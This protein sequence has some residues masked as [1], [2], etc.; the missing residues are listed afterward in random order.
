MIFGRI[1]RAV[2]YH[3]RRMARDHYDV[4]GVP[5]SSSPEEI[6]AA[7][8]KLAALHHPDRNPNDPS[9]T[10]RFKEVTAAYQVL[11]DTGRRNMYDR[12]GHQAEASGSPFG[13]GGPF[14]GG[15]VDV[16]DL[17]IDGLLGD[18]LGVF[19]VGRGDRGDLKRDL[20]ISFEEAAFGCDK[21][22]R[23]DR[24]VG[25]DSCGGNGSAKGTQPDTCATC[26]GRG[27][28]R[29]QQGL[30]P[31]AVERTCT[32]CKGRGKTV[33]HACDSCKG[34]GLFNKSTTLRVTIPSG[35]EDAA[36]KLVQ[37]A[38]NRP[39]PEKAPGD[40]E[41]TIHVATHPFFRRT[42]DDVACVVPISFVQAA[43]G[44]EVEVPTLE[45]KGKVRIPAGT[46]P[47]AVV[48][49]KG[50]G[51]PKRNAGSRGDQLVEV[52]VEVPLALTERQ[53]ELL[54]AF[55]HELG[56]E[57]QPQQRTF[58]DKLKTLFG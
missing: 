16:S 4:L 41:L 49:L 56:E 25:C 1:K 10:D 29:F 42:H 20:T 34:S 58:I 3:A 6:K 13:Q 45:G 54:L 28:V 17:N 8:K 38:G 7:F 15:I 35:V 57:V 36:T 44:G 14:A 5:R 52:V 51:I 9:A 40:L 39:R 23:Y 33:R 11:G 43:L 37:G 31:I 30:I 26:S 46:Q 53:R 32:Q 50:Q 18:L 24:V 12:F 27:R 19:G 2:C 47:H 48:R 21:E 55:A 22:F